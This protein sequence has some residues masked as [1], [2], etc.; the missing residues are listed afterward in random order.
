MFF[1]WLLVLRRRYCTRPV[2]ILGIAI[3]LF[4]Q[5]LM[6]ARSRFKSNQS[7]CNEGNNSVG[8]ESREDHFKKFPRISGRLI[9]LRDALQ[10][11]TYV[12]KVSLN[13]AGGTRR[14]I[15]LTGFHLATDSEVQLFQHSLEQH[16]YA[17]SLSR[18]TEASPFL[19]PETNEQGNNTWDILI[20]L[21]SSEKSCL[22][23]M[24]FHQLKPHQKVN[25]IP[26]LKQAF[27]SKDGL[28]LFQSNEWLSDLKLPIASS[29]CAAHSGQP[30]DTNSSA[31]NEWMR[32]SVPGSPS[33]GQ[34]V[35]AFVKVYVL[36][37]SVTPLTAFFHS[38]GLVRSEPV[39]NS[40]SAKLQTLFQ[41]YLGTDASLQALKNI[42]EAISKILM[43]AVLSSETSAKTKSLTRFC[44]QMMTFTVSLNSSLVPEVLKVHDELNFDDAEDPGFDGQIKKFFLEDTMNFVL[45]TYGENEKALQ[46]LKNTVSELWGK[47]ESYIG[48]QG[49]CPTSED[50]HLIIQ[51][52]RQLKKQGPFELLYPSDSPQLR[53]FQDNL[54][55]RVYGRED[56]LNDAAAVNHCV[57]EL[58]DRIYSTLLKKSLD[59][60]Q[61]TADPE[62]QSNRIPLGVVENI[63]T[64]QKDSFQ[65]SE[66][67]YEK[68]TVPHI[69]QLYTDPPLE[70]TPR[71]TP[72]IKE[73]YSEVPF[74]VVM[75]KIRAEPVNCRCQ[76][77]LE[78]RKGPRTANYPVGLGNSRISI[79]V[80]DESQAEPVVMTIYTI[81]I[82][83]ENRP[84][85]PVFDDYV[86][87]GFV[88]DC[89]LIIRPK[90]PCGLEPVPSIPPPGYLQGHTQACL[91]G[92]ARGRWVVPCLSCSDNRTCDWREVTWQPDH[93]YHPVLDRL[94]LQ[95]CMKERKVL[96]IGDSTNRGMMFYLMERVNETLDDWDKAHDTVVYHNV[97]EGKTLISY[98]YYPQFWLSK[99]QRPTFEKALQHLILRSRPLENTEQTVIVVGGVQWLST[100]HLT[101][102]HRVLKREN[103]LN[104]LVVIKTLGMGFHLHVDGIRS[105]SLKAVQDLYYE[106]EKILITAQQHGYEV[107]DTFS[108]T[109]GRF[110][111]FLQG[112]CACHFH[113]VG[114]RTFS[115]VPLHRKMKLSR[116]SVKDFNSHSKLP[117]LQDVLSIS[118]SPYHVKG[119][120]NQVYS[121][122]LLSRICLNKRRDSSAQP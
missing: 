70:L 96:F 102:I 104:I 37:T 119:P 21:Q 10:N 92:D 38:T 22:K 14:A 2:L 87:C 8:T 110:K 64:H 91:S 80:V 49:R 56:S 4:Y 30:R 75:V 48:I 120:I 1:R 53:T 62:K 40:Y 6:V 95:A 44:F 47:D 43:A 68:C 109:M 57:T 25:M 107:I 15:I 98:S 46:T 28:C 94:Q 100:D 122:I 88:Q 82:Y 42:K 16:G 115:D 117:G 36:I 99:D 55:Q 33:V 50:F 81:N 9:S 13:K 12:E 83:R 60:S 85:L 71:F 32:S 35:F 73:Y 116:H 114:K 112:R 74:D 18:S 19:M 77:H 106:N 93:C 97:N 45:S 65:Q 79:L 113:E 31:K 86:M 118:N 103:L 23:R 11:L 3:C 52:L 54:S 39:K 20:C 76:V 90:E 121:E 78:E 63:D 29:A 89:G 69:R 51:F 84:S 34:G 61:R 66:C 67:A 7:G 108:I 26:E 101:I 111:E 5:T 17:V 27:S 41:K 59:H 105:L 24:K 72:R 58:L